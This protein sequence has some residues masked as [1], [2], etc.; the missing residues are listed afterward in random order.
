MELSIPIRANR[1]NPK[2][3]LVSSAGLLWWGIRE[4][5]VLRPA[6]RAEDLYT[7]E[8]CV[9]N[10]CDLLAISMKR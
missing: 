6:A 5:L 3:A 4:Y 1:V 2:L 10:T 8:L 9:H 7:S